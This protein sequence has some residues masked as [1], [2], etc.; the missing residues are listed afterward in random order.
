MKQRDKNEPNGDGT[1]YYL[2]LNAQ[3]FVTYAY[4]IDANPD[5]DDEDNDAEEWVFEYN[6]D[7]NMTFMNHIEGPNNWD[8]FTITYANGDITKVVG[9][10]DDGDVKECVFAYTN[11]TYKTPVANIGCIMLYEDAF[12]VNQLDN[13]EIAY[14]AGL[15]GKASKNLPMGYTRSGVE[16]NDKYTDDPVILNWEFNAKKLPVK[17]WEG[18]D[19]WYAVTFKW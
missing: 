1:D 10:E 17:F 8:K 11:D 5:P 4:A 6:K 13:M 2:E 14:Y 16:G 15:L 12:Q 3:G 7:G 18:D 9:T 19:E